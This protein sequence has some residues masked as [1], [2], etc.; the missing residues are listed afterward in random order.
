MNAAARLLLPATSTAGLA[1]S[2]FELKSVSDDGEFEGYASL[3]NREDLG[4]DVI[5]PGAFRDSLAGRNV[6]AIKMLFQHNPS[7]P[8]GVWEV[9]REDAKGLY[10]K[11][12][13]MTAVS[14]AREVLALMRAGALD[15]LSIGFKAVKARRDARSGVR[16]LEKVDLWE[17]SVVTFPMLP[18]ARVEA[19]KKRPFAANAPTERD[20][21]R[22]LTRD[23]GLTRNEARAITRQGFSGLRAVRGAGGFVGRI[24]EASARIAAETARLNVAGDVNF[25]ELK[26]CALRVEGDV[27]YVR[28]LAA[29]ERLKIVVAREDKFNPNHDDLGRFTTADGAV[30]GPGHALGDGQKPG[31]GNDGQVRVAQAQG[32]LS[33]YPVDILEEDTLG[34][35][36][37][38][39]HIGK[40]EEYLKARI[41][42]SFKGVP[43]IGG[44]GE[45]RAGSFTSLEAANKLVSS[46]IAEPQ[47]QQK[48]RSFVAKDF[49]FLLPELNLYPA[50][51][52]SA[53]TGYE[54]YAPND[55]AAPVM[56]S[57]NSV[58]IRIFRTD[59][60]P[61]GYFIDSA[62]PINED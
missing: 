38:E 19:V 49:F 8:I 55:R 48:L 52:F 21:E 61:K 13:L 56:R 1:P 24:R 28:M 47:N 59:K 20:F 37:Y 29:L 58:Q 60:S 15:G 44:Y 22:W 32:G 14:K 25:S 2:R 43:E 26:S 4:H 9:I 3:F 27:A 6:S 18:G 41:R 12:R 10:V 54:A 17:I 34:G 40:A 31:S 45:K 36:T 35:H 30:T 53:P 23:A 62:F 42:G 16:R 5:A 7:D 33:A 11:G 51:P 57:T 39:R 46:V 50:S